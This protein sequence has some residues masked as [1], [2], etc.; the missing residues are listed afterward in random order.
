MATEWAKTAD[1]VAGDD[2]TAKTVDGHVRATEHLV[3]GGRNVVDTACVEH[4]VGAN[5]GRQ[6]EGI[7]RRLLSELAWEARRRRCVGLTLEVRVSNEAAKAM[8]QRF[9]YSPAGVR[10]NYYSETNEDA[11]VMW[12]HDADLEAYAERLAGIEAEVPG[13]TIIEEGLLPS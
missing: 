3:D 10:K 4:R 9:G 8:Y 13:I 2:S 5:R 6:R 7:G 1:R 12:A 11:L